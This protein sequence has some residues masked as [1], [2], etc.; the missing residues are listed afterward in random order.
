MGVFGVDVSNYQSSFNF[1]GWDFAFIKASEG[2]DFRDGR[3]NQHLANARANN[4]LV[5][6]YHYQRDVSA[7]SQVNL[8][9]SIVPIDVPV[10]LD[11]ERNSGSLDLTRE[12]I[13]L[14]RNE[15]YSVPFLY[16][17]RWYW[18]SIGSPS[19]AGLPSLWASWYPDY[20]A[21]PREEGINMVPQSAWNS[22]G[23]LSVS[24]MQ[25]T[26]TPF[27][28]DYFPG[29]RDQLASILN[30]RSPGGGGS[31]DF[32]M[33]LTNEEQAELLAGVR[34]L[35]TDLSIPYRDISVSTGNVVK[36]LYEAMQDVRNDL[37]KPYTTNGR[38]TGQVITDLEGKLKALEDLIK[39]IQV[40]GVD[41]DLLA[42]A[43]L[44]RLD[45]DLVHRKAQS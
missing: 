18:Q 41:Y 11:V 2:S 15:G 40:G 44:E 9:K 29:T 23:G 35:R 33:A 31:G 24:I 3:F 5:A 22:Y 36:Y 10:I 26:S 43:I 21:R 30:G 39:D 16:L 7:Q 34:D 13:R 1:S 42:D 45:V 20:V 14:L 28:Q 38:S 27:D 4:C 12:V 17:P 6:A 8:I 32:L 25:F 19:L 37:A